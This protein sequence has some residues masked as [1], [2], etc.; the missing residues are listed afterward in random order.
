MTA[1][2]D[3]S[4]TRGGGPR[5]ETLTLAD[6]LA[7][8]ADRRPAPGGGAVASI[9]AALG[10]ALARMVLAYSIGRPAYAA[11]IALH[12][13][14]TRQ[15]ESLS[16]KALDLAAEDAEVSE[17]MIALWKLPADDPLRMAE[18]DAAVQDAIAAPHQVLDTCREILEVC[19]SLVGATNRLL[20]SDLAIAAVLAEAAAR[21]AAWNVHVNLPQLDDEERTSRIAHQVETLVADTRARCGRIEAGCRG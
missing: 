13:E 16:R 18:W 20:R 14:A 7:A 4:V 1:Q 10:T 8:V 9:T 3:E 11:H 15:L 5:L 17:R 19:E 21:A 6:A 2:T 12:E